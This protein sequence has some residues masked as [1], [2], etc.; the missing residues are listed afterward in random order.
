MARHMGKLVTRW[1]LTLLL[2]TSGVLHFL[3]PG[4][5]LKIMPAYLPAP[6][7]LVYLSGLAELMC[8]AGIQVRAWRPRMG[9]VLVALLVA[10]FPANVNQALHH[11]SFDE[12]ALSPIGVLVVWARLPLQAVL[13]WAA[14]WSTRPEDAR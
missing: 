12:H 6:L 7:L 4:V 13:I 11:V 8:G 10:I 1:L 5:F 3:V 9:Y 14:W 2:V